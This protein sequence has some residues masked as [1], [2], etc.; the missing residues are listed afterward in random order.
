LNSLDTCLNT[1][2]VEKQLI[3][4]SLT[5]PQQTAIKRVDIRALLLKG[6]LQYQFALSDGK[7]VTHKNLPAQ[8]ATALFQELF[9]AQFSQSVL[10]SESADIQL[11]MGKAGQPPRISTAA[12]TKKA[13]AKVA[14][15]DREKRRV[16]PG[17]EP[18]DFLVRLG[19]MTAE[20]TVVSAR[21]DKYRQI[22]RFL[23]MVA[24]V[25]DKLNSEGPLRI[26]DF[27][28]GKSYL[29][30][31]LYHYFK[32]LKQRDVQIVGLDL[33]EDV[34]AFCNEVSTDLGYTGLHFEVGEI[35][36]YCTDQPVDM[37][38]SLHACD[39][40]TD[41]ALKSAVAWGAKVILAVPCCQHELFR[42]IANDIDRPLLKHGILKERLAALVTDAARAEWLELNGYTVQVLEF[43]D[44]AHTPKN[45]LIRAVRLEG[46]AVPKLL[47]E[48][49]AAFKAHWNIQPSI[50][51]R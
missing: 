20:G 43:I 39:T 21:F 24:D 45:L 51:N 11:R 42:Q 50:D 8:A 49:Y 40:A 22:N 6:E 29:T 44:T 5:G 48:G 30:F 36:G 23:E 19:V 14:V 4:G 9:P 31:A 25:A 41:D 10:H 1:M 16:V 27:G 17:A 7:K 13:A 33:K 32:V 38:V 47:V 35:S 18:V 2:F 34:I 12:P 46:K 15:H 37:V 3:S 26:I 28:S